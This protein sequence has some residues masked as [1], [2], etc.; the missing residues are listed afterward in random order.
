MKINDKCIACGCCV[1]ICDNNAIEPKPRKGHG[2]SG[3][4]IIDKF[5][6]SCG[7]CL[8]VCENGAVE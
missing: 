1:E 3:Y 7:E 8:V 2:Y 6:T 4:Q 5:C